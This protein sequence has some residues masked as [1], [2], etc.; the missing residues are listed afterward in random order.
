MRGRAEP[1]DRIHLTFD[2]SVSLIIII[3]VLSNDKASNLFT[4]FIFYYWSPGLTSKARVFDEF[5]AS[6]SLK[7]TTFTFLKGRCRLIY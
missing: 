1:S 3:M 7:N 6:T 2:T 4:P 5:N